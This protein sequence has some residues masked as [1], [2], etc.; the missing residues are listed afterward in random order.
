MSVRLRHDQCCIA[1]HDGKRCQRPARELGGFCTT[2]FRGLSASTRDVLRWEAAWS[3]DVE[4]PPEPLP[5]VAWDIARAAEALL[6]DA[7]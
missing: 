6:G 5:P 4:E 3:V 7:A 2:C 1:L